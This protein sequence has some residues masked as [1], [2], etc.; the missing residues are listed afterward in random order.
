MFKAGIISYND[1]AEI[2]DDGSET[3]QTEELLEEVQAFNTY[4]TY[5]CIFEGADRVCFDV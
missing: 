2:G 1:V 5:D 3:N 4:A